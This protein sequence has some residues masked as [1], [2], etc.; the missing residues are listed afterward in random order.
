LI[1]DRL[2]LPENERTRLRLCVI[3]HA[4][5]E[6]P[7]YLPSLWSMAE[8]PG[9]EL[10]L[11]TPDK[12]RGCTFQEGV[13]AH[14]TESFTVFPV[15][16][17]FGDRQGTF[18]Y[19]A[20]ALNK[21]LET[22][23]PDL[24][25]HEQEVYSLGSG[26]IAVLAKRLSIPFVNFVWENVPR[27]LSAPRRR[28]AKFV[29]DRCSGLIAGSQGAAKLCRDWGFAGPLSI[30]PQMGVSSVDS[31]PQFGRRDPKCFQIAFAGRLVLEKGVDCL[32]RAVGHIKSRNIPIHCTIAGG[33]PEMNSLKDLAEALGILDFLTM[34]GPL[35][36]SEVADLL[37][38]VDVLVLPSRTT[39]VWEEQFGRILI[40][41]MANGTITIGS[42]TGAIPEV[43]GT[44]SLLFQEGDDGMLADCL[45][46]L[47]S[48]PNLIEREQKFLL[49][50]VSE[51]YLNDA[52]A[53]KRIAF[54]SSL[55]AKSSLTP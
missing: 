4:Y 15:P 20:A 26:Q 9:V 2:Q 53:K 12:Y 17:L 18:V 29:M 28:L 39:P 35:P 11:I 27:T 25:L 45:G 5:V 22:F 37:R 44:E 30:L 13:L 32:L 51:L 3:S 33:G 23:K 31:N 46:T 6:Q 49:K 55:I 50:R 38:R 21:V 16:I 36:L 52:L 19:R 42:K 14:S 41:A 10:A 40:E 47:A 7:G 34:T 54:L 1:V 24:L 8:L 48:D 43:I